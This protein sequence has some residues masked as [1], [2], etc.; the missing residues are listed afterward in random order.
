MRSPSLRTLLPA[1]DRWR[2][3][4]VGVVLSVPVTA[5]LEGLSWDAVLIGPM[6]FGGFVA[7]YLCD[8]EQ[9]KP[10]AVGVRAGLVGVAP[11]GVATLYWVF[12]V[13]DGLSTPTETVA[14][15]AFAVVSIAFVASYAVA[16]G[17]IGALLGNRLIRATLRLREWAA[18]R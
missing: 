3:A 14:Y 12:R 11:V 1:D 2:S 8:S 10:G 7:G 13:R 6:L 15:V 16:F 5:A 4:V 18:A 9:T 17:A